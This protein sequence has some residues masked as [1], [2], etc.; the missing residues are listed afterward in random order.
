VRREVR[1]HKD[2]RWTIHLRK[3]IKRAVWILHLDRVKIGILWSIYKEG[4]KNTK[5]A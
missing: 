5:S 1:E 3:G 2:T 4:F